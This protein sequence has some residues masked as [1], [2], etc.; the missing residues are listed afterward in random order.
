MNHE[1]ADVD[2]VRGQCFFVHTKNVKFCIV[3]YV[4]IKVDDIRSRSCY[5][6][7]KQLR[8]KVTKVTEM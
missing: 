5:F 4:N 1:V 8:F 3:D 6:Y 2:K 7:L